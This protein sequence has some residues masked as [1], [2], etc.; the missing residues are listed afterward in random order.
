MRGSI[1][2]GGL[3]VGP[4]CSGPAVQTDK[5]HVEVTAARQLLSCRESSHDSEA[6]QTPSRTRR[7]VEEGSISTCLHL[8]HGAS[9]AES[10]TGR[11][12]E[13]AVPSAGC[14]G[15]FHKFSVIHNVSNSLQ[16]PLA[17]VLAM[18]RLV[19]HSEPSIELHAHA[20]E[21]HLDEW[22]SQPIW[23]NGHR[24]QFAS[25]NK[26]WRRRRRTTPRRR[27]TSFTGPPINR[28][29][30]SSRDSDSDVDSTIL[31][32]RTVSFACPFISGPRPPP[33]TGTPA[34]H[35][36]GFDLASQLPRALAC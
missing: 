2:S 16:L 36:D 14:T 31:P 20:S 26:S 21:S 15:H 22:T 23:M 33:S 29:L 32:R 35:H 5:V 6:C 9:C 4:H 11:V 30:L 25:A 24:S 1:S 3:A 13:C 17:L 8:L 12:A 34:H 18:S 28:Q 7:P 27:S 10:L 19:T